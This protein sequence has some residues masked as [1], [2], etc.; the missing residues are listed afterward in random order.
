[1]ED[2]QEISQDAKDGG[3]SP[4]PTSRAEILYQESPQEGKGKI[5]HAR[6]GGGYSGVTHTSS[7]AARDRHANCD[8]GI[9]RIG[10]GQGLPGRNISSRLDRES[11]NV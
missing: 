3:V 8:L 11:P 6:L 9:L 1:M 5:A 4:I 7:G 2:S 10:A